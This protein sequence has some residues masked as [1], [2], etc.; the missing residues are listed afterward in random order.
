MSFLLLFLWI[1]VTAKGYGEGQMFL[2]RLLLHS[3]TGVP[4]SLSSSW[5]P[6]C[7]TSWVMAIG[8]TGRVT[9]LNKILSPA[10]LLLLL[11]TKVKEVE[12]SSYS[13]VVFY[14]TP[15]CVWWFCC[16]GMCYGCYSFFML[17]AVLSLFSNWNILFIHI[18]TIL[19]RTRE[20]VSR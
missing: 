19:N 5:F 17:W 1:A 11:V 14:S 6:D 8:G 15:T 20:Q 3:P 2:Q 4:A 13:T 10:L 16:R 9:L 12:K 18:K 7:R